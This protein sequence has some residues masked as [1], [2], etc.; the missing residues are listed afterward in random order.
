LPAD[1]DVLVWPGDPSDPTRKPPETYALIENFCLGTRRLELFGRASSVR[2]GWVTLLS[3]GEEERLP[4][5]GVTVLSDD[6]EGASDEE[7]MDD[8]ETIVQV[9]AEGRETFVKRPVQV[10]IE[11]V[12]GEVRAR[13]WDKARWEAE[14]AQLAQ[15]PRPV[16]PMTSGESLLCID[17]QMHQLR[18]GWLL[19]WCRR[20]RLAPA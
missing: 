10:K 8:E 11:E 7:K 20:D 19:M 9:D 14:I 18:S 5:T 2:R 17:A 6:A 15:G 1:T 4:S 16:V 13:L 3:R 12:E